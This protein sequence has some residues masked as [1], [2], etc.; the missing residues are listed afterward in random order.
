MKLNEIE[1]LSVLKLL[2]DD[3]TLSSKQIADMLGKDE[4][5]IK[6]TIKAYEESGII[7]GYHTVI[8]SERLGKGPVT[9]IIE[10]K[11]TPKKNSGFDETAKRICEYPNVESVYLTSGGL[12]LA[13][14]VNAETML[15]IG[16]FVARNLS[17]IDGVTSTATHFLMHRYK[18]SGICYDAHD[19]DER[20]NCN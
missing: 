17:P 11:L 6:D 10:V 16:N 15:D 5:D 12:D 2:K 18:E 9:A 1:G 4:A 7:L 13:V 8:N 20:G 3:A 14:I 19:V